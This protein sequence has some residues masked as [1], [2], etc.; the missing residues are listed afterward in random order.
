MHPFVACVLS[1]LLVELLALGLFQIVLNPWFKVKPRFQDIAEGFVERLFLLFALVLNIQAALIFF[2]A[3][4]VATHIN[5]EDEPDRPDG[6]LPKTYY[7]LGN[8]TS[9]G[10]ALLAYFLWMLWIDMPDR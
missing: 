8:L 3:L 5:L 10:L 9:V 2:G 1:F 7:L 4:K 6:S